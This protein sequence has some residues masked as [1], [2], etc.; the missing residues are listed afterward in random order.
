MRPDHC[1]RDCGGWI[2]R[3]VEAVVLAGDW[4]SAYPITECRNELLQR[5]LHRPNLASDLGCLQPGKLQLIL[6]DGDALDL[7]LQFGQPLVIAG[8]A[9]HLFMQ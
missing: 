6:V 1:Q 2:P 8:S 3:P 9:G 5:S 7:A 4:I